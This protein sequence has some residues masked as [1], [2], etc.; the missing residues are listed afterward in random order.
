MRAWKIGV[1]V[2]FVVTPYYYPLSMQKKHISTGTQVK[3]DP[4][5]AT[6]HKI[7]NISSPGLK[8]E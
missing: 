1:P 4:N 6:Q 3:R 7:L 2:P 8:L 5:I